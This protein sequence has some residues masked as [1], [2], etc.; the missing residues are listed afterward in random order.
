[1]GR[2]LASVQQARLGQHGNTGADARDHRAFFR[3]VLDEADHLPL[4]RTYG[5]VPCHTF[6]T[7]KANSRRP[8]TTKS[9]PRE[10]SMQTFVI[11][12][13]NAWKNA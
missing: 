6:F 4:A 10:N 12:R 7:G 9:L 3:L 1:V 8:G 11:R 5:S 13:R 2:C